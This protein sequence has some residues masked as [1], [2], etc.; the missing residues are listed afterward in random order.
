MP[1]ETLKNFYVRYNTTADLKG[2]KRVKGEMKD[3]SRQTKQTGR[4][5]KSFAKSGAG[6]TTALIAVG[7]A[8]IA[9]GTKFASLAS[10]ADKSRQQMIGLVGLS[11]KIAA[12]FSSEATK[13]ASKYAQDVSKVG[14]AFYAVTSAGFRGAEAI[15]IVDN[16]AKGALLGLGETDDIVKLLTLSLNVFRKDGLTASQALDQL[17]GAARAANADASALG[18]ILPQLGVFAK[19]LGIDFAETAGL[20]AV[21]TRSVKDVGEIRTQLQGLFVSFN[22]ASTVKAIEDLGIPLQQFHDLVREDTLSALDLLDKELRAKF[23]S[24]SEYQKAVA[25]LFPRVQAQSAFRTLINDIEGGQQIIQD[26]ADS[27][28]V[29]DDAMNSVMLGTQELG[30][31]FKTLQTKLGELFLPTVHSLTETL[32]D[33]VKFLNENDEAIINLA[34]TLNDILTPVM[35][36]V[37]ELFQNTVQEVNYLVTALQHQGFLHLPNPPEKSDSER[38]KEQAKNY[39]NTIEEETAGMTK[40]EVQAWLR[41]PRGRALASRYR[42][43]KGITT[44]SDT[45][46]E[47]TFVA[48]V[49]TSTARPTRAPFTGTAV[50]ARNLQTFSMPT[51]SIPDELEGIPEFKGIV[52]ASRQAE[53]FARELK[54][55]TDALLNFGDELAGV[56]RNVGLGGA[57]NVINSVTGAF[58][59]ARSVGG[60]FK[61]AQAAAS[62]PG[63]I[64]GIISGAL[65]TAGPL[66]VIA[67]GVTLISGLF[68]RF[69]KRSEKRAQRR[70]AEQRRQSQLLAASLNPYKA[71]RG[72]SLGD[73]GKYWTGGGFDSRIIRG[74]GYGTNVDTN[75]SS[76]TNGSGI[77]QVKVPTDFS[78]DTSAPS[79]RAGAMK[80]QAPVN[81]TVNAAQGMDERAVAMEV[82]A[83]LTQQFRQTVADFG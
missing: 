36:S 34:T 64:G 29:T 62:S 25:K 18:T 1:S 21:M 60:A 46:T 7:T 74:S 37:L 2:S 67:G 17:T 44:K 56:L 80:V 26:I 16:A 68:K 3:V 71:L 33:M 50:D 78:V 83:K 52:L 81:I 32:G 8:A 12:M 38:R 63:G 75:T 40:S 14:D 42:N 20:A 77:G 31:Q 45:S 5:F 69:S 27:M 82:Q 79:M 59:T 11:P 47:S 41:T 15:Q 23:G 53:I 19:E 13:I 35:R 58:D 39:L 24:G 48:P 70:L 54:E 28:G 66:G 43:A 49:V 22:Q 10:A 9:L 61:A 76:L 51:M 6:V 30:E 55:S 4:S 57:G 65:K 72:Q 73:I